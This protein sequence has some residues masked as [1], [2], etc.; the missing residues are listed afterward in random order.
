M[1][2]NKKSK[3]INISLNY[4]KRDNFLVGRVLGIILVLYR[5]HLSTILFILAKLLVKVSNSLIVTSLFV[6]SLGL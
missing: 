5:L 1:F 3:I 6:N 4:L 2:Q